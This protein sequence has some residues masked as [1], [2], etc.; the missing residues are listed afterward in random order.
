MRI[1]QSATCEFSNPAISEPA[2]MYVFLYLF[3]EEDLEKIK[4]FN[5]LKVSRLEVVAETED[6]LE[7]A[8]EEQTAYYNF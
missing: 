4:K 7:C 3:G 1:K 8:T 5:A 6:T 2:I